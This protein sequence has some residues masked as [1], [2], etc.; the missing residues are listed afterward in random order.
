MVSVNPSYYTHYA[1]FVHLRYHI[2]TV[3]TLVIHVYTTI[4]T[5]NTPLNTL[6]TPYNTLYALKQPIN[7]FDETPGTFGAGVRGKR[8]LIVDEVDDT[9]TTLQ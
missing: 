1:P 4:Y 7:R 8:V 2:Y 6:H 3:C 9:R 5:P